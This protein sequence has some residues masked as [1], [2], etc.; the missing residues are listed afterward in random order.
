MIMRTIW[1]KTLPMTPIAR[2]TGLPASPSSCRAMATKIEMNSTCKT[3][4]S[5]KA[6]T[7][8]SGKMWKIKS[9]PWGVSPCST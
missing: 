5:A 1:K 4:P 7:K 9:Y 6:P 8:L 2:V 3:S